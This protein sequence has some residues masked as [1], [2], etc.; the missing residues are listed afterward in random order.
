M[1]ESDGTRLGRMIASEPEL[2]RPL[3]TDADQE[4]SRR[5]EAWLF[6]DG[7]D[8]GKMVTRM[9]RL[10]FET[11]ITGKTCGEVLAEIEEP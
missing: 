9:E 6:A 1:S 8:F 10:K 5:F 2:T 7:F 3:A 4:T 11:I